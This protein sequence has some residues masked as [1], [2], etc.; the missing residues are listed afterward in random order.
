M[1]GKNLLGYLGFIMRYIAYSTPS[2]LHL[3]VT[4]ISATGYVIFLISQ[5][6]RRVDDPHL[7]AS[8]A[9]DQPYLRR[10]IRHFLALIGPH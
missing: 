1:A 4:T 2:S 6:L 10:G 7:E 9:L 8:L 3:P 5:S